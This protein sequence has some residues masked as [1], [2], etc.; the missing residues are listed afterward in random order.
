MFACLFPSYTKT[1]A[2]QHA[3]KEAGS[4]DNSNGRAWTALAP[5]APRIS[6]RSTWWQALGNGRIK[7][8]LYWVERKILDSKLPRATRAQNPENA[9]NAL[10]QAL[11]STLRINSTGN[12]KKL[13]TCLENAVWYGVNVA[14]VVKEVYYSATASERSSMQEACEKTAALAMIS[15]CL[16]DIHLARENLKDQL[17]IGF[18]KS[19]E[20]FRAGLNLNFDLDIHKELWS[21]IDVAFKASHPRLQE[22]LLDNILTGSTINELLFLARH[23]SLGCSGSLSVLRALS[24]KAFFSL[25]MKME[26]KTVDAID[27]SALN[28]SEVEA[29]GDLAKCYNFRKFKKAHESEKQK[30]KVRVKLFESYRE[31]LAQVGATKDVNVK[32]VSSSI[33][34]SE[35]ACFA[36]E[37]KKAILRE[38]IAASHPEIIARVANCSE[39]NGIDCSLVKSVEEYLVLPDMV[40]LNNENLIA[41][42]GLAENEILPDT[43][44]LFVNEASRRAN[45]ATKAI[46]RL[47]NEQ[48]NPSENRPFTCR[49]FVRAALEISAWE[50]LRLDLQKATGAKVAPQL[51]EI[52][53]S[54]ETAEKYFPGYKKQMFRHVSD[55]LRKYD[56]SKNGK[57]E[58]I[59]SLRSRLTEEP[60]ANDLAPLDARDSEEVDEALSDFLPH[61][62]NVNRPSGLQ[63]LNNDQKKTLR[64]ML[65]EHI[66]QTDSS[67]K[68]A[69]KSEEFP[70]CG[71][72]LRDANQTHL[73]VSGVLIPATI[74]ATVAM[75]SISRG[76]TFLNEMKKM[77]GITDAQ[78]FTTSRVASQSIATVF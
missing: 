30:R 3:A 35:A 19:N 64:I 70:V 60:S 12:Q 73:S 61:T 22:E 13:E 77:E 65:L 26:S 7:G 72:F 31:R 36:E 42:L 37:V 24:A 15:E 5:A 11:I 46:T 43:R 58:I 76:R 55:K 38:A 32:P 20:N 8:L 57:A 18:L 33:K 78:I 44:T 41:Y 49:R 4:P 10:Q 23:H 25:D 27:L 14:N 59:D 75:H 74:D 6:H 39:V 34:E 51:F 50:K 66:L 47:I 21:N 63:E 40:A 62:R 67:R 71:Q 28:D 53:M 68:I 9:K 69:E 1:S 56:N 2:P 48:F 29:L 16:A 17:R 45:A 54:K 52:D